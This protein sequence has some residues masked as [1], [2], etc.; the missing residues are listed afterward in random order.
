MDKKTVKYLAVEVTVKLQSTTFEVISDAR[1]LALALRSLTAHSREE[2]TIT[3]TL[4]RLINYLTLF[5]EITAFYS[6]YHMKL[7]NTLCEQ[8][9]EL[10]IIIA[11]GTSSYHWTLND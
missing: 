4:Q 9:A 1:M 10:L 3:S 5:R 7:N 8:N 6:E 2:Y 11:C